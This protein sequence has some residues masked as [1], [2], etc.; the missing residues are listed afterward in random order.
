[1]TE[2][3]FLKKNVLKCVFL[4]LQC[5]HEFLDTASGHWFLTLFWRLM[6]LEMSL[7]DARKKMF[8]GQP[9]TISVWLCGTFTYIHPSIWPN[10]NNNIA[11]W[12][13]VRNF[14]FLH[15]F[16]CYKCMEKKNQKTLKLWAAYS[17]LSLSLIQWK[18][19]P[20]YQGGDGIRE[21]TESKV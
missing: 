1:M 15:N 16:L 8:S 2:F 17:W 18:P 3:L 6:C 12:Q 20:D 7:Q 14:S 11:I 21:N 9:S 4:N 5:K 13:K 19:V 10:N